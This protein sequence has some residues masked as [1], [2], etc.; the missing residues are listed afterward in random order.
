MLFR[1]LESIPLKTS[2]TLQTAILTDQ[3]EWEDWNL[4]PGAMIPTRDSIEKILP[5]FYDKYDPTKRGN[6]TAYLSTL[7]DRFMQRLEFLKESDLKER[8]E[9]QK[10]LL[11]A[12]ELH[13]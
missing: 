9:L 13:V 11:Q 8:P 6:I 3:I 5:G 2:L 7:K 4:L 1:S 10:E 12:L